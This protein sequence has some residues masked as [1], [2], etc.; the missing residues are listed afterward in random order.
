MNVTAAS[1]PSAFFSDAPLDIF[2]LQAKTVTVDACRRF[3]G[4]DRERLPLDGAGFGLGSRREFVERFAQRESGIA[5]GMKGLV[6]AVDRLA[7][8]LERADLLQKAS[9]GRVGISEHDCLAMTIAFAGGR[10]PLR[11]RHQF[12]AQQS[13]IAPCQHDRERQFIEREPSESVAE[14]EIGQPPARN[15]RRC[16]RCSANARGSARSNPADTAPP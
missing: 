15:V 12:G 13:A 8:D 6:Q 2:I 9:T 14:I 3:S 5:L 7:I 16:R 4:R 10:A 1:E 11:P